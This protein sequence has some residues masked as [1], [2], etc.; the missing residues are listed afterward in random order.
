MD[1]IDLAEAG[2]PQPSQA[3]ISVLRYPTFCVDPQDAQKL[4]KALARKNWRAC[5]SL[6]AVWWDEYAEKWYRF[7]PHFFDVEEKRLVWNE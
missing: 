3:F 4:Q 5:R 6:N 7:G 1:L 2:D